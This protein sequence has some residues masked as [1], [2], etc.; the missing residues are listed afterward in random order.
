[1]DLFRPF[2]AKGEHLSTFAT[3]PRRPEAIFNLSLSHLRALTR[4]Y[5]SAFA[6]LPESHTIS[7]V[8][9]PL[10]VAPA[11]LHYDRSDGWQLAFLSFIEACSDLL[12]AHRM[13]EGLVRALL[14]MAVHAGVFST[15]DAAE[16]LDDLHSVCAAK[17]SCA[18]MPETGFVVDQDL[19]MEDRAGAVGDVLAQRFDEMLFQ[20]SRDF[21]GAVT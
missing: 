8:H 12:Q 18:S 14:G 3:S 10:Y 17:A 16:Y 7:W 11:I 15:P 9:G 4:D 19:A 21:G 6:G 13:M 1:M 5:Y 2:L 20:E